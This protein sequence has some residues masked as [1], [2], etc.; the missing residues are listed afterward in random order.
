MA[1][2]EA[3]GLVKFQSFRAC[4]VGGQLNQ[5]AAATATLRECPVQHK[6]SNP[7]VAFCRSNTHAL[8]LPAKL[9]QTRKSRNKAQLQTADDSAHILDDDQ[10]LM[11]VGI[12]RPERTYIV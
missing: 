8:D 7:K 6:S 1:G 2:L 10:Q 11:G 4:F 3:Q 5:A 9:P 12:D